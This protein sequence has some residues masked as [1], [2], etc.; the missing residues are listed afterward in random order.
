MLFCSLCVHSYF[1]PHHN[2]SPPCRCH[3]LPGQVLVE[4][5]YS[6]I[7][8]ID[9]YHRSGLYARE[10]P[11]VAGQEAGGVVAQSDDPAFPVGTAVAYSTLGT[12]SEYTAVPSAKL[13]TVPDHLPLDQ[14]TSL[15]VQGLTAHYL[16]TDAHANLIAPGQWMLIHAAAGGTG[17]LAV[18]MAKAQGYKV[19]GTCSAS[20]MPIAKAC[21][22]DAVVDYNAEDVVARVMEITDGVGVHCALDGVGK[23]T[24]DSS[25]DSLAQ[26]GICV[27]FGNASGPVEPVS[28]LRLI[29]KSTFVTRP[30]L[31][32]YTKD[33]EELDRRAK[34][35]FEWAANGTV[36]VSVDRVFG[37][38]EAKEAHD[39][40]EG[41]KT[42]GKLLLNCRE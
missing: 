26:R 6:G 36:K 16:T 24:A 2:P 33:R 35:T 28:P 1:S 8:F 18:Q 21:G 3:P 31:L 27:F 19:I 25:L 5:H 14:A 32:D 11:F 40:I 12:Y 17:Q 23:S 15:V 39:Y 30:K 41:G 4:N 10:L 29:G 38:G 13:L 9:T 42:T 22:C 34:E 7:N 37:L 20:K